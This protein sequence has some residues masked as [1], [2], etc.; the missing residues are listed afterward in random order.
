MDACFKMAMAVRVAP[1]GGGS[2]SRMLL[3]RCALMAGLISTLLGGSSAQVTTSSLASLTTATSTVNRLTA[4]T[5]YT[6]TASWTPAATCS[7][8]SSA[9]GGYGGGVYLDGYGTYWSVA[10]G[11]DWDGTV[12]YDPIPAGQPVGYE[13][14]SWRAPWSWVAILTCAGL[15]APTAEAYTTASE[16]VRPGLAALPSPLLELSMLQRRRTKVLAGVCKFA[17]LEVLGFVCSPADL[18]AIISATLKETSTT[19]AVLQ[20]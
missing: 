7:A 4:S 5:T 3:W 12:Y 9:V 10:C 19:T 14:L 18:S 15:W 8:G 1:S 2:R 20:H 13:H 17:D 6:P 11:Y 16:D